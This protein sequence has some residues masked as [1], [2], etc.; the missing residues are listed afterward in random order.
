MRTQ[1]IN[2]I[3]PGL[4]GFSALIVLLVVGQFTLMFGERA[5]QGYLLMANSAAPPITP[6]G[7]FF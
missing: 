3:G 6:T 1:P 7:E 2:Y 4:L 5:F